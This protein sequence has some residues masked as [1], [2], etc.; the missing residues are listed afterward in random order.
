[1][2][3]HSQKYSLSCVSVAR[4]Q[5]KQAGEILLRLSQGMFVT[6]LTLPDLSSGRLLETDM[7][8]L[9]DLEQI[10]QILAEPLMLVCRSQVVKLHSGFI[11]K[12]G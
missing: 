8:D 5:F 4:V 6:L 10:Y 3:H 12:A 1:M 9:C 7:V 2:L 11:R